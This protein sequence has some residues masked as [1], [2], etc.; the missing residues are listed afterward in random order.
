[1]SLKK[2]FSMSGGGSLPTQ[3]IPTILLSIVSKRLSPSSL[4]EHL[5]RLKIPIIAR[6]AE[7]EILFD[8]RTIAEDEFPYIRDGLKEIISS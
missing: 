1:M 2:G 7:D 6:I 3:E 4:E 5:R 8:I